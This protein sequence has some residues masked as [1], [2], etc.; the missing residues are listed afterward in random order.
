MNV[1]HISLSLPIIPI[2]MV[3]RTIIAVLFVCSMGFSYAQ[4]GGNTV[5]NILNYSYSARISGLG[6]GLISVDNDDPTMMIQ[7][8]ST[9]SDKFHT[10]FGINF[11]DYFS[12]VGYGSAFY[13]HTFK[14]MG[15]FAFELRYIGYGSFTNTDETG[16][17]FGTFSVN[18]YAAT[19]GWG[20]KLSDNLSIG[21]NLKMI[22]SAYAEN[23]SFGFATDVSGTYNI[24]DKM[25]SISLLFKNMGSQIV[26]YTPGNYEKLPF[27]IQL[28]LSKRLEHVPV[29]LHLSLHS[30]YKWDMTYE[31]DD[32]PLLDVDAITG[33]Y[34]Y[35]SVFSQQVNNFF[36]HFTFGI[37]ILP[38]KNFS[39]FT[40]FNYN[41]NREMYIPQNKSAA[42]FSYGLA[43]NIK[44]FRL[45]LSRSH[46][47][48]GAAPIY[49]NL[50]SN[51]NDL[52]ELKKPTKKIKRITPEKD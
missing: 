19:V 26:T 29:R 45:S 25:F 51:I 23:S 3:K 41:R 33:E 46:Y 50:A 20:R 5:Y 12:N 27:D 48:V 14:K 35:P 17:E 38:S 36:R 32:D 28:A 49:I 18:D 15:S 42:G 24:P 2:P 52:Y 8:P 40:S 6:G 43:F 16:N 39:L 34:K 1:S 4:I 44:T 37:E 13:S 30:L 7:N 21:A 47:A 11:V 22:Y 31:G 9:I 10:S